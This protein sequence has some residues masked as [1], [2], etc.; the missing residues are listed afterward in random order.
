MQIK[1]IL[2]SSEMQATE[3]DEYDLKEAV[4]DLVDSGIYFGDI[5]VDLVITDGMAPISPNGT[6]KPS[7][8]VQM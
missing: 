3:L 6:C 4:K 1:V 8:Q 2:T 7:L 5:Q